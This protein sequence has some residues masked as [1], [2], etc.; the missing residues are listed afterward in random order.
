MVAEPVKGRASGVELHKASSLPDVQ[1][2]NRRS[3]H[4]T[5]DSITH[6]SGVAP[7]IGRLGG[8]QQFVL[9]RDDPQ[10]ERFLQQ[11]PDA[12]PHMT[13]REQLDCRPFKNIGLWK[14]A[15]IEGMG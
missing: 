7:F 14:A 9:N 10:Y 8:N 1:S 13:L 3:R 11:A 12:A 6:P 4:A 2:Y 5:W 15:V